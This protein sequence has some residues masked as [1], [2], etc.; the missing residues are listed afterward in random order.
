MKPLLSFVLILSV[1][2]IQS[3]SSRNFSLSYEN[4]YENLYGRHPFVHVCVEIFVRSFVQTLEGSL[5]YL[6]KKSA[7]IGDRRVV[8]RASIADLATAVSCKS[9]AGR[10]SSSVFLSEKHNGNNNG[11]YV[12][13]LPL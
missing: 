7:R 12:L 11:R 5:T 10:S 1:F 9:T 2:Q 3:T 4:F 13:S 8:L 6:L